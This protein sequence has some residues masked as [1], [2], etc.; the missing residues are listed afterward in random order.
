MAN[1]SRDS[2]D[3]IA[4]WKR[5][6]AHHA[7]EWIESGMRVGLGSGSTAWF[8]LARLGELLRAGALDDIVGVPTSNAV[9]AEAR[10]LK[11]PLSSDE[12]PPPIDLTIDGADQVDARLNLIKGGGGAL[13]REKMIAQLTRR[14]VIIV[15]D[16][17]LA[18]TLGERVSLP[19]EVIVFGWQAQ[20]RF[21][22]ALGAQV[23]RRLR[24]DGRPYR[25]D[26]GNL[27]L[28]AAFGPIHHPRELAR[29]LESRA[30]I[31]AHGLFLDLAT[32]VVV[33]GRDG[34]RHLTRS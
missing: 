7:V 14:Q 8:A 20:Q 27:I 6:A 26:Q 28:D 11:I 30:G 4:G 3:E 12:D 15:D 1:P 21:L 16:T 29:Q 31:V 23:T 24:E 19:V 17:K 13:L 22:E 32:D 25:T 2:P 9:E 33:A 18:E 10:R 5:Q 34:I